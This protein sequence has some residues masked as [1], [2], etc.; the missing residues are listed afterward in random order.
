[1]RQWDKIPADLRPLLEEAARGVGARLQT[2]IRK[3][4]I[5]AIEVMKE[6][7]LTVHSVPPAVVEEW[8]KLMREEGYPV[9]VGP[10]IATEMFDTVRTALEEYRQSTGLQTETASGSQ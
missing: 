6:H 10:R 4:E 3:L 7:G 9:F 5:E 2:R 1:M 8:K